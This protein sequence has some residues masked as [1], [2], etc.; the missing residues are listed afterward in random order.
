MVV[1]SSLE[2]ADVVWGG[3]SESDSN[4]LESLQK[5]GTR[6][7]TGTLKGT[8][9]VSLLN[10]LSWVELSV[11]RK[12]HKLNLM[13]K[14]VFKLAPPYLCDLCPNFVSERSSCSLRSANNLCLPFVRTERY[15]KSF[16]FSSIQEWNS[17]PLETRISSSPGNF[18]RNLLK[19]LHFPSR[20]YLFYIGDRSASIFH[21]RL[22]LNFSTLNYHLYQK[23]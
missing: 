18:K 15:K 4:L 1:R 16:L 21:T 12:I 23:N 8:N 20:S 13:Y 9:R 2:Y 5:E 19:F 14:M 17:L 7:V 10:D 3:C 11:R 6:V 22:R